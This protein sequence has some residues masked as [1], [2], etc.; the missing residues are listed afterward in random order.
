M[1]PIIGNDQT[2]TSGKPNNEAEKD[3]NVHRNT[4]DVQ[5]AFIDQSA[6]NFLN[7]VSKSNDKENNKTR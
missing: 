6:Y 3:T 2:F 4:N 1:T 5:S 7:S